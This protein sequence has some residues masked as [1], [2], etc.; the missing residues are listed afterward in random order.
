MG[1]LR[2]AEGSF[3]KVCLYKVHFGIDSQIL[4]SVSDDK[5]VPLLVQGKKLSHRKFYDQLLDRKGE[6]REPF[7]HLL[8]LSCL[9]KVINMPDWHILG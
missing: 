7:L 4:S 8:F 9:H 2:E 5:N 3:S 1:K 6:I